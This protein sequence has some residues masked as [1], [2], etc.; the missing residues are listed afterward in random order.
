MKDN[1]L[2]GIVVL[3][4]VSLVYY[5]TAQITVHVGTESYM[6]TDTDKSCGTTNVSEFIDGRYNQCLKCWT[7]ETSDYHKDVVDEKELARWK[8]YFLSTERTQMAD[9][10]MSQIRNFIITYIINPSFVLIP[11]GYFAFIIITAP[12][13]EGSGESFYS[14]YGPRGGRYRMS[15]SGKSKVYIT[16][17]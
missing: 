13:Y 15:A 17:R 4:L 7:R 12:D 9:K 1:L 16:R 8:T 10:D 3:A 2:G 6:C 11:L 5:G 14:Q